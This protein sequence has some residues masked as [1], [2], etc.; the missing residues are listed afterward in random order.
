M[1]N[2]KSWTAADKHLLARAIILISLVLG[3]QTHGFHFIESVPGST[4]EETNNI[5]AS[6]RMSRSKQ[7]RALKRNTLEV[8]RLEAKTKEDIELRKERDPLDV[9]LEICPMI[10]TQDIIHEFQGNF[11]IGI[12]REA[13]FLRK[14]SMN[15]DQNLMNFGT[16]VSRPPSEL[17]I[18]K[19][20]KYERYYTATLKAARIILF[21]DKDNNI[22]N[23]NNLQSKYPIL[24]N[25]LTNINDPYIRKFVLI[26]YYCFRTEEEEVEENYSNEAYP[27]AVKIRRANIFFLNPTGIGSL[28]NVFDVNFAAL[29]KK[30]NRRDDFG[31]DIVSDYLVLPITERFKILSFLIKFVKYVRR[32]GKFVCTL[33]A[34]GFMLIQTKK[35]PLFK[36]IESET[37]QPISFRLSFTGV[38]TFID[39][40]QNC[41]NQRVA[42][43]NS[44]YAFIE[45]GED[46]RGNTM[47][48]LFDK[49]SLI[50]SFV[51]MILSLETDF[52]LKMKNSAR[53]V[54]QF[55]VRFLETQAAN[56]QPYKSMFSTYND[57]NLIDKND[58]EIIW[59]K[60]NTFL[61]Y[62]VN[63]I[64]AYDTIKEFIKLPPSIV[65]DREQLIET[66][67]T[68][69]DKF[70]KKKNFVG[71]LFVAQLYFMVFHQQVQKSI[72]TGT[73]GY[74]DRTE[75]K[76]L[77]LY[78][79]VYPK[80]NLMYP[81]DPNLVFTD[82]IVH[83]MIQFI[84]AQKYSILMIRVYF[85][86]IKK[87]F[88]K[89]KLPHF[90]DTHDF[91]E[92]DTLIQ[93]Y[94]ITE[95]FL[96]KEVFK[97]DRRL[98]IDSLFQVRN[99][100]V[101]IRGFDSFRVVVLSHQNSNRGGALLGL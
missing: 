64:S 39:N 67:L 96:V 13:Q 52:R 37:N 21:Y 16:F 72:I 68:R 63:R 76:F 100:E 38:G 24:M 54:N 3:S 30:D 17:P 98:L 70:N 41:W 83:Q 101:F 92:I 62:N 11:L 93:E 45:E 53:F 9:A 82:I 46:D 5:L 78:E 60:F 44:P 65:G 23:R 25:F 47:M 26:S 35:N 55:A 18:E 28:H 32:K 89:Y 87:L 81:K 7:P 6:E 84:V 77:D 2:G 61:G 22:L 19:D 34:K 57:E 56:D 15:K 58:H 91:E 73:E 94:A 36:M 71:H 59:E 29:M 66:I 74:I 48:F 85:N 51:F 90:F 12:E 50:F 20:K 69:S 31:G 80:Q 4:Q 99:G 49:Y 88:S 40:K 8:S 42:Q 27:T 97:L 14:A 86:T 10:K 79:E 1:K 95:R 43:N 75:A 33:N